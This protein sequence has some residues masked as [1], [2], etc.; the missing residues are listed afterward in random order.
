MDANREINSS[1]Y[2]LYYEIEALSR[3]GAS[4]QDEPDRQQVSGKENKLCLCCSSLRCKTYRNITGLSVSFVL[5]FGS[6]LG[7][8]SLQSSINT[9]KG[10]GLKASAS[11]YGTF[12]VFG[13]LAPGFVRLVGTKYGL[14]FGYTGFLVYTLTNYYPLHETLIPGSVVLGI[15]YGPTWVSLYNHS[16]IVAVSYSSD[17]KKQQHN[18]VLFASIIAMS[19]KIAGILG[20]LISSIVLMHGVGFQE[21]A[22]NG[23]GIGGS[24]FDENSTSV[25]E[26]I[27]DNDVTDHIDRDIYLTLISVYT[28]LDIVAIIIVIVVLD[29]YGTCNDSSTTGSGVRITAP[30][31]WFRLHILQ[32]LVD[33]LTTVFKWRMLLLLPMFLINGLLLG[34]TI[35]TFSQVRAG[36]YITFV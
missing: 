32:P 4:I 9:E 2:S 25:L 14:V 36:F 6:F 30:W 13:F 15:L 5:V 29:R 20:N 12:I 31:S 3:E 21:A 17:L 16:T 10:L 1:G 23:S 34:F 35:G 19:A 27:C 8:L 28:V 24:G 26:S 11:L 18:I 7:L 22:K 33:L